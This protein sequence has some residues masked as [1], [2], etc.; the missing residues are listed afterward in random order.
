MML[1]D[2]DGLIC[3]M[4]YIYYYCKKRKGVIELL[5]LGPPCQIL[6]EDYLSYTPYLIHDVLFNSHYYYDIYEIVK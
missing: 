5:E 6:H 4:L 3:F 1:L 2:D